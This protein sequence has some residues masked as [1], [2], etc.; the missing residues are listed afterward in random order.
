M[1]AELVA[2]LITYGLPGGVLLVAAWL[3][4]KAIDKKYEIRIG[5]KR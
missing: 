1:P 3:I 2:A 5:P 4:A